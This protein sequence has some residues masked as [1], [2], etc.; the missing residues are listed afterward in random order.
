MSFSNRAFQRTVVF[1][2][3]RRR[4]VP[5]NAE[6]SRI[7][8]A[9]RVMDI[10]FTKNTTVP[11]MLSPFPIGFILNTWATYENFAGDEIIHVPTKHDF[12]EISIILRKTRHR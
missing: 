5:N 2:D 12:L 9:R 1:L 11:W 4:A 8:N 6:M 10:S 7:T 3:E